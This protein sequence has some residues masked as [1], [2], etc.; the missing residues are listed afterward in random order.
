M[1]YHAEKPVPL[2]VIFCAFS[3]E[4]VGDESYHLLY[5]IGCC[6]VCFGHPTGLDSE[7]RGL[8]PEGYP[9]PEKAFA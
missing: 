6:Y 8:C 9:P 2:A 7:P 5:I 1:G 4:N 3:I